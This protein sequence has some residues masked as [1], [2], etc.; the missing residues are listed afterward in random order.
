MN[1]SFRTALSLTFIFC[2]VA[3]AAPDDDS[4]LGFGAR[5]GGYGFRHVEQSRTEWT[6][7]RMDGL[8]LFT[9]M[10]FGKHLFAEGGLDYYQ[11]HAD[12]VEEGMDRQSLHG[13]LALGLRMFPDFFLTPHVQL[14]GGMEWTDVQMNDTGAESSEVLPTGFLGVG[15]E[16]NIT[17]S[18]KVG[19]NLRMYVM[20]HP[21]HGEGGHSHESTTRQGLR[22]TDV[23]VPMEYGAAGQLQFFLRYAL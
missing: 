15:G 4:S 3:E 23:G 11:A 13:T 16:L 6:D 20:A 2:G 12:V 9:T 19:G 8:G 17:D 21:E 14:G 18:L 5:V 22:A 10:A 1:R 7:C